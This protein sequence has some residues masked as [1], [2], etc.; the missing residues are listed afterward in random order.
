LA[1]EDEVRLIAYSIWES[2]GCVEG[3]DCEHWYR[4]ETIWEENQKKKAT[5]SRSENKPKAASKPASKGNP[6][7]KKS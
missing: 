1:K 7:A 4:A 5:S 6:T 3:Y 2:E